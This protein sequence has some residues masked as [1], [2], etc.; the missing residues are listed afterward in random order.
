M[1]ETLACTRKMRPMARVLILE[2]DPTLGPLLAASLEEAG[3]SAQL[4]TNSA[5]AIQAYGFEPADVV[6]ADIIIKEHG[7]V[8]SEGGLTALFKIKNI[9]R[10]RS[11]RVVTIAITGAASVGGEVNILDYAKSMGADAALKKA[12]EPEALISLIDG[13]LAKS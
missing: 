1:L 7:Q 10:R 8:S 11:R 13:F 12:F 2:D 6:I 5:I 9:A 4:Y 3:H